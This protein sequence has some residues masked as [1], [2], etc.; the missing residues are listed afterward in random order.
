MSKFV[1]TI[2]AINEWVGL[3]IAWL[4]IPMSLVSLFE[5][6]MRYVINKPTTWA[7]E[8]N[9]HILTV[10]A[11]LMGGYVFLHKAHV[12]VDILTERLS[13]SQRRIQEMI[14]GVIS[15]A[16][17]GLLLY[18]LIDLAYHATVMKER[19]DSM[20]KSPVYPI[21]MIACIGVALFLLQ[22][23]ADFIRHLFKQ[24]ENR[25]GGDHER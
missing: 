4:L 14:F 16:L 2:D 11:F 18:S 22:I 6:V 9:V 20:F 5:V 15:F 21:E 23:V 24:P 10:M 17:L 19:V 3:K 8:V 13:A 1:H 7:W 25:E 12:A